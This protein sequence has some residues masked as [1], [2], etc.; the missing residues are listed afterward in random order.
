[1]L[2]I[3]GTQR[4]AHSV[5]IKA[6]LWQLSKRSKPYAIT[7]IVFKGGMK[8]LLPQTKNEFKGIGR[9]GVYKVVHTIVP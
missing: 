1:M 3:V 7:Q 5:G 2:P 9:K 6:M 4:H 8:K